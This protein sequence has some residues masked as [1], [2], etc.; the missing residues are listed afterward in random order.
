MSDDRQSY[1]Q[2]TA[3]ANYLESIT[4]SARQRLSKT[5]FDIY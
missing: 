5:V 2:L 3:T 4:V 1:Q